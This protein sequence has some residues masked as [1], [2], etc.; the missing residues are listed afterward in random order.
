MLVSTSLADAQSFREIIAFGNNKGLAS[1]KPLKYAQKDAKK[2]AELMSKIGDVPD[3]NVIL[4]QVESSKALSK[5]IREMG[6]KTRGLKAESV[7]LFFYYVG[8]GTD[9]NIRIHLG[10]SH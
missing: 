9:K 10:N 7:T 5:A 1:E 2:F 4:L 8:H 3:S 6:L